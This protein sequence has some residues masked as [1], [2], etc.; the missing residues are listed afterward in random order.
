MASNLMW[1]RSMGNW[2]DLK[3]VNQWTRSNVRGVSGDEIDFTDLK[4]L[5]EKSRRFR[6]G[7]RYGYH[8][9]VKSWWRHSC[10]GF[11]FFLFLLLLFV[12]IEETERRHWKKSKQKRYNWNE[13]FNIKYS[14]SNSMMFQFEWIFRIMLWFLCLNNKAL[15]WVFSLKDNNTQT[16]LSL[17]NYYYLCI[18]FI[19]FWIFLIMLL[20]KMLQIDS[21]WFLCFNLVS[22]FDSM[23]RTELE[24]SRVDLIPIESHPNR[25]M[26]LF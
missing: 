3:W 18:V 23:F 2:N 14:Y 10:Y 6:V 16:E 22:N 24:F 21:F 11:Q 7:T 1:P 12:V 4:S 25:K 17:F 26:S 15:A 20:Y 13:A 9:A 19:L 8:P 5:G